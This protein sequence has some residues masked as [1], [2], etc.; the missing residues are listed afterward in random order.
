MKTI[1]LKDILSIAGK[2]GLYRFLA[3]ARNGIVIESLEDKKRQ[4]ASASA[5]VS[6]LEDIA[7]FTEEAEV[8]LSEVFM[9]L[10]EKTEGGECLSHK[11]DSEELKSYFREIVPGYD[12]ERVYVSDI[13]KVLQWYNLLHAHNLLEVIEAEEADEAG[14]ETSGDGADVPADPAS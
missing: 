4:V 2:G 1:K 6:S 9:N 5:R 7:I 13:K 10:H 11:S 14:E 3:Q 8:P 12:E